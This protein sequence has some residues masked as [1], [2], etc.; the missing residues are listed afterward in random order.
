MRF[1]ACLCHT[2]KMAAWRAGVNKSSRICV[3]PVFPTQSTFA[4]NVQYQ[5]AITAR[6]SK[7]MKKAK[8]GQQ[9]NA[10]GTANP[11]LGKRHWSRAMAGK[12]DSTRS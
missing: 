8:D 12:K 4:S 10:W 5:F 11:V 2:L 3:V 9:E 6:H 7:I 1:E